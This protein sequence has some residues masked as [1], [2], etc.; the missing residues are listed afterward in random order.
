M[1]DLRTPMMKVSAWRRGGWAPIA[2]DDNIIYVWRE[3]MAEWCERH[4]SEVPTMMASNNRV[5]FWIRFT[6]EDDLLIFR[7]KWL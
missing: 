2:D 1:Y 6:N 3:N 5:R 7:L 4:L